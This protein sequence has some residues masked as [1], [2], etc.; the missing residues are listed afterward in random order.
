MDTPTTFAVDFETY[1][2]RDYSVKTLGPVAY[3]SDSRFDA[4]LVSMVGDNGFEWVGHPSQA[5]WHQLSG[6]RWVSHN[7]SFD[8]AVFMRLLSLGV[9]PKDISPSAWLCTADLCAYLQKPR[10]LGESV[11]VLFGHKLN[12]AI[13]SRQSGRKCTH[14]L[15]PDKTLLAYALD[16]AR[17]C[18]KLWCHLQDRWPET[19]RELSHLTRM[20]GFAG[21]CVD[22]ERL[23]AD[24]RALDALRSEARARIPWVQD[25]SEVVLSKRHLALACREAGIEPPKSL[26]MDDEACADWED[27]YGDQFP[28]VAAMRQW[29]RTNML[30]AKYEAIVRRIQ[31]DGRMPY[32]LKYC[33]AQHTGRWSGDAGVN[34]QNLPRADL[35]GVNLRACFI[36]APGCVFVIVDFS[37]IEPRVLAWLA[38]DRVLLDHIHRCSDFYEAQARAMGMWDQPEPLR[39]NPD[40]R[41]RIKQLNLGLAYGMGP[42]RFQTITGLPLVEAK[43]LVALYQQKNKPVL[44]MR[45]ELERK[46]RRASQSRSNPTLCL[47]LPS[48]RVIEYFDVQTKK[49]LTA[50]FVQGAKERKYI[51]GPLLTENVTQAVAREVFAAALLRVQAITDCRVVWHVHDEI[52]CEVPKES[53]AALQAEI[54]RV[55]CLPPDW[56]PDL[57][58]AV[59]SSIEERYTK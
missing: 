11:R 35:F 53:A 46:A 44:T 25:G 27:R 13:R 45:D 40:L 50:Q 15:F 31:A 28:W 59:E 49:G 29:R 4:Y 6:H 12:K 36:P 58:I 20:W 14:D 30:L 2:D 57:P 32:N 41:H 5:P 52:I 19:E 18:L 51:T 47:E 38:E 21:V 56:A 37:Q 16:D 39:S 55:M 48:G 9:V 1:Y 17:F 10:S 43:K 33:G 3:A 24:M 34:L 26:A 22:R 8:Q 54:E 7:A 23:A 42:K